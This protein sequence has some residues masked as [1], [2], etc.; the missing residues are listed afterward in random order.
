MALA[1]PHPGGCGRGGKHHQIGLFLSIF[2][3]VFQTNVKQTKMVHKHMNKPSDV[4]FFPVISK[5]LSTKQ[6]LINTFQEE[7]PNLARNNPISS[8]SKWDEEVSS[9]SATEDP[10]IFHQQTRAEHLLCPSS[11]AGARQHTEELECPTS[12]AQVSSKQRH[13]AAGQGFGSTG[14]H[15]TT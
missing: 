10:P 11:S 1:Q 3:F 12:T 14:R 9:E 13:T 4:I 2:V 5:R 7:T 8:K 15:T 6:L